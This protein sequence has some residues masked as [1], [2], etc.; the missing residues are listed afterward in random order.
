M[1]VYIAAGLPNVPRRRID[2]A[3]QNLYDILTQDYVCKEY[4]LNPYLVDG[5]VER[6]DDELGGFWHNDA[7]TLSTRQ[8][9]LT[10]LKVL[11]SG[12]FQSSSKDCINI[13]QLTVSVVLNQ[14][15]KAIQ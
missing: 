14:F 13:A 5:L 1:A 3:R 10:S 7:Y 12:S 8:K 4:R 15:V 2:C 9:V 11:G 6:L